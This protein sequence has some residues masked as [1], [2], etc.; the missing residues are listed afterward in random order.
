[1]AAPL[2]GISSSELRRGGRA[3]VAAQSEPPRRELALGL[4]YPEAVERAGGL[5]VILSPVAPDGASELVERLDGLCLSGGP[6]IHPR[7][8][9]AGYH[10][11]I[12]PTEPELDAFEIALVRAALAR[13]IPLLAICRGAQLLNVARGGT[14]LQH[15][16]DHVGDTIEHRQRKPS[17]IATH[18]VRVA[19]A[20]RLA[21]LLGCHEI[22]TNSFH[23]QAVDRLGTALRAVAWSADGVVEAIEASDGRFTVGV[24]WHAEC[25]TEHPE[26][27]ALFRGFIEAA[28]SSRAPLSLAA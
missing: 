8:Y 19:P 17:P 11:E 26:Q 18:P 21:A 14:L 10:R 7:T 15:L 12:G 20:S 24:Q 9:G 25:M 1:M 13:G 5:P 6:D 4:A 3:P 2:I 16:P 22:Q 23:H 27:V 28:G